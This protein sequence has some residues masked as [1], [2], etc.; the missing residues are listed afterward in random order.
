MKPMVELKQIQKKTG[1][2]QLGPLDMVIES[3]TITA[4]VGENGAGK[5]TLLKMMMNLVKVDQGDIH[6]FGMPINENEEWKLQVAYQPQTRFG[7]ETF[8]LTS[9]TELVS[10]WYP[11]WDQATFERLI[12]VFEVPLRKRYD[13]LSQGVQKKYNLALVI[14]SGANLLILDEP[15]AHMD[16]PSKQLLL[17]ILSDWMEQEGRAII[18]ATHQAEDIRK[19]ADYLLI[20]KKGRYIGNYEKEELLLKYKQY[21][22]DLLPNEK[23]PGEIERKGKTMISNDPNATE[24]YLRRNNIAYI[25]GDAIDLEKIISLELK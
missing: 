25:E 12:D 19:L 11:T 15:T 21:W 24:Y 5:S 9:I 17:D 13:K 20:I 10:R 14:A 6:M 1:D 2:F 7:W 22:I 3:G 16:I 18:L 4:L 8:K 23:I